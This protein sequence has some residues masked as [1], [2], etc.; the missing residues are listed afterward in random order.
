M[1]ALEPL[2]LAHRVGI[3]TG[4]F[5]FSFLNAN[6][7]CLNSIEAGEPLV[8]VE[9]NV[10][11]FCDLMATRKQETLLQLAKV[12][13]QT[14]H[15]LMGFTNDPLALSGDILDFGDA[16]NHAKSTSNTSL[17]TAILLERT[18]L[19]YVFNAYDL[20]NEIAD[21]WRENIFNIPPGAGIFT[22]CYF[23]GLV[24]LAM[25]RRCRKERRKH[26]RVAES[27]INRFRKWAGDSPHNCLDKL[28]LLEAERASILGQHKLAYEK[29]ACANALAADSGCLWT[30]A[31]AN[32]RAGEHLV[33]RGEHDVAKIYFGRACSLWEQW[34]ALAKAQKLKEDLASNHLLTG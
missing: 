21:Q 17:A 25:A 14:I 20:A 23:V 7:F 30:Q 12:F 26:L 2:R 11:S 22:A 31:I 24:S 1:E 6:L 13:L 18:L 10:K 8:R 4:D 33:A 16:F 29:Y 15:H 27:N 5:E 3:E 9:K 19:A 28:F 34:G 32:E